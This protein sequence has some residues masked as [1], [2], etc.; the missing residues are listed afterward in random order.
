M[1]EY[2]SDASWAEFVEMC[3]T[4][5]RCPKS[6]DNQHCDHWWNDDGPCHYCGDDSHY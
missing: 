2:N 6:D 3:K 4:A 5:E 1:P